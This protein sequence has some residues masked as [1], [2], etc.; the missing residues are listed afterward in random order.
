MRQQRGNH[1]GCQVV[2]HAVNTHQLRAGYAAGHVFAAGVGHQRVC[3]A[4]Q[5]QRRAAQV[6]QL[7]STGAVGSNGHH[8]AHR[9]RRV[10]AAGQ[11]GGYAVVHYARV[12]GEA[13]AADDVKQTHSVGYEG[14]SVV[15]FRARHQRTHDMGLGLRQAACAAGA[16]DA[17]KA[18]GALWGR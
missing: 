11:T 14:S 10:V 9:S 7:V 1:A 2:P 12:G 4:V 15:S 18:K 5:H 16:H 13:G 8:L 17:G 3:L 6:A